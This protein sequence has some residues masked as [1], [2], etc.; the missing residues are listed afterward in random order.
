MIAKVVFRGQYVRARGGDLLAIPM[1]EAYKSSMRQS[2]AL[3]VSVALSGCI[4]SREISFSMRTSIPTGSTI[5]VTT[6]ADGVYMEEEYPKSGTVVARKLV[7]ALVPH[8]PKS[9]VVTTGTSGEY[10]LKPQILHWED[11]A[12]EWSGK[13]DRVKVS[14]PL[15]KSERLIGSALVSA[16]SSYWTMGGDH[17]ED[18]LDL[19]FQVYAASL[20]GRPKSDRLVLER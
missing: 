5:S 6:P 7:G 2:I 14:L 4:S 9:S 18:L 8:F 3:L 16:K 10:L 17:P 19:P 11:R 13:P 20:A 15:Y 12:T 1:L